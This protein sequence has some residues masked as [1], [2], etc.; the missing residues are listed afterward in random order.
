MKFMPI[1]GYFLKIFTEVTPTVKFFQKSFI[2]FSTGISF[3]T[4]RRCRHFDKGL[5]KPFTYPIGQNVKIL[6]LALGNV[7]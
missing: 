1:S 5:E 2:K 4:A 7:L 6:F 3:S